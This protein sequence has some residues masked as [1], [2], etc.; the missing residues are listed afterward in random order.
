[1]LLDVA[2]NLDDVRRTVFKT[3]EE[4]PVA[5]DV[6]RRNFSGRFS[7]P[8]TF[9]EPPRLEGGSV[10][11]FA[12]DQIFGKAQPR[13]AVVEHLDDAERLQGPGELEV[14]VEAEVGDGQT[15]GADMIGRREKRGLGLE[16]VESAKPRFHDLDAE[17]RVWQKDLRK[18]K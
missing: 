3:N 17:I 10:P 13:E 14:E 8:E 1:M 5:A 18:I 15:N 12:G 11:G 16:V 2:E 9:P 6:H 7:G 4:R